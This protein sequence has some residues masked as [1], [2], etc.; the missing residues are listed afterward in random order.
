MGNN[1][2]SKAVSE[3][4]ISTAGGVSSSR[5]L[6]SY[7]RQMAIIVPIL[8]ALEMDAPI[9]TSSKNNYH[10][11]H[12]LHDEE[13]DLPG[14]IASA[15]EGSTNPVSGGTTKWGTTTSMKGALG[16]NALQ[17]ESEEY[18]TAKL[19]EAV[20]KL[21]SILPEDW[22]QVQK[23]IP[24]ILI[25]LKFHLTKYLIVFIMDFSN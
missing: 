4:A 22:R 10:H 21:W 14:M 18:K 16:V 6:S 7:K 20:M 15:A 12:G 2:K 8:K 11:H 17:Q 24:A 19:A 9:L 3:S 25:Q 1:L 23:R 13:F 5:I